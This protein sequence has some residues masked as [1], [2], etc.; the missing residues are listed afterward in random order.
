MT[1]YNNNLIKNTPDFLYIPADRNQHAEHSE[2]PKGFLDIYICKFKTAVYVA[3]LFAL[4]SLP[5]AY[6]IL[7]MM[8]KLISNNIELIDY[9]CEEALPLGRLIMSI[10]VGIITFIL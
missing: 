6:K 8:A 4:L 3:L 5:I 2:Q 7:D 9:E 10:I 1:S